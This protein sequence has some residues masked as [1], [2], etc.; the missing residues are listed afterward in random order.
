MRKCIR[1]KSGFHLHDIFFENFCRRHIVSYLF[2]IMESRKGEVTVNKAGRVLLTFCRLLKGEP[3]CIAELASE[4]Q[5][6]TRS[7][8][9]DI[10]DIR[11]ALADSYIG[12][13]LLF[14]R[15]ANSY[16]LSNLSKNRLNSMDIVVLLKILL[17]SR[18]LCTEEM[19][20]LVQ[21]VRELYP[22]GEKEKVFS[23]IH[24]EIAHY[25]GPLHGKSLIK[26]LWDLQYAISQR[27]VIRL[28]YA[29]LD[30]TL[31]ER[32]VFPMDV[33]CSEFYFYLIA[34]HAD[35]KY[36]YPAFYRLDRMDSFLME[37]KTYRRSIYQNYHRSGM[38]HYAQ[39][40][41]AGELVKIRFRCHRSAAEAVLDRV[42]EYTVMEEQ[43]DFIFVEAKVFGDGFLRWALM[44]GDKVEILEP[45]EMREKLLNQL[46]EM[47]SIYEK[48][49][50]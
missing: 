16:C 38:R 15:D 43:E 49:V 25:I 40:M 32:T 41:Y 10:Y 31:V 46:R 37:G 36:E 27:Q 48:H 3:V 44:Q 6:T 34:F 21:E 39:F 18:C 26:M 1:Q 8:E 9:R 7:I 35:M 4:F 17:G 28:R 45:D 2:C 22:A 20:G 19:M 12:S 24:A 14:D 30:G 23:A 5:T 47:C 50:E 29:K 33:V 11:L 42:P 13:E